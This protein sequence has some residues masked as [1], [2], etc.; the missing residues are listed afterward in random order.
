MTTSQRLAQYVRPDLPEARIARQWA[1]ISA[2]EARQGLTRGPVLAV[3]GAALVLV[4]ALILVFA[5]HRSP[6][7][8]LGGT[9]VESGVSGPGWLVLPDG[10]RAELGP[11]SRVAIVDYRADRIDLLL[12]RG[13]AEFDVVPNRGRLVTVVAAD[14]E[15]SV[16]GTR[17]SVTLG[18]EPGQPRLGVSVRQGKVTVRSRNEPRDIRTL[19]AGE[20]WSDA[21]LPGEVARKNAA[22]EAQPSSSVA[23]DDVIPPGPSADSSASAG[24]STPGPAKASVPAGP[25][26]LFERA[27]AARLGGHP[28]EAAELL[29][30]LRRSHRGDARA[31]LAAFELGRLRMD[32]FGDPAGAAEALTDAIALSRGAPFR[33][34]AESRLV[35]A[36]DRMGAGERCRAAQRSYLAHYPTGANSRLIG[37]LCN[38]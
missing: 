21:R 23:D 13:R 5:W 9:A 2:R 1:R 37:R 10:T 4:G 33:E 20:S 26:E 14:F 27:E 11:N 15:V 25:K 19:S 30:R 22:M 29:D 31:G 18:T 8:A 35:Q 3:S 34:D 7:T 36:F 24:A 6:V 38:R 32:S 28:R 12:E 16:V 17:F